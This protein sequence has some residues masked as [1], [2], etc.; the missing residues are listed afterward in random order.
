MLKSV[1]IKLKNNI[2][3]NINTNFL[4][5]SKN[6]NLVKISKSIKD[7]LNSSLSKIEFEHIE[8]IEK[9][10]NILNQS[11]TEIFRIDYGAGTQSSLFE[12]STNNEGVLI[13]SNLGELTQKASKPAFWSLLLFNFIKNFKPNNAIEM[14]TCVGISGAYQA[15][16]LKL[17]NKG[18]IVTLEGDKTLAKI[19]M[20]NFEKLNL[21]N[22]ALKIGNFNLTL[23]QALEELKF[24]DYIFIDG[25]HDEEATKQYFE[26]VY[27]YLSDNSIVIFDDISWSQ[28]MKN[29]WNSIINNNKVQ[30]SIDF[31]PMGLCLINKKSS[32]QKKHY[33]IPL[34]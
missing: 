8:K 6:E 14:G 11:N 21:E 24:L 10:R 22:I 1:I 5:F 26:E 20:E 3:R 12:N 16:A 34:K 33:K 7:T 28:G 30:C 13:K 31:G 32:S 25:H 19:A 23:H 15:T 4:Q 2:Y 27:P 9:V 17:N 18:F 29:A